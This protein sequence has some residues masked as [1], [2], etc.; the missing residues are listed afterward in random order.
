MCLNVRADAPS[1]V[2]CRRPVTRRALDS[3]TRDGP[4]YTS[5]DR[6]N[7]SLLML[8]DSDL[9][10][11]TSLNLGPAEV[12]SVSSRMTT[13]IFIET[14]SGTDSPEIIASAQIACDA[15]SSSHL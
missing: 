11:S 5:F 10:D 2:T 1:Q 15:C 9:V 7:T 13:K 14:K 3:P 4:A 6:T 8:F 12:A